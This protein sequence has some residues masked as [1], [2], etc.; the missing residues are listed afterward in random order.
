M[1]R[2]GFVKEKRNGQLRVCFQR[3]EACEGCKGCAKG[4]LP[5][6]E[7]LT[8]FGQAEVGDVVDVQM[9]EARTLK[10]TLLAYALPLLL[11]LAGLGTASACGLSDGLTLLCA[12]IGLAL[13][14]LVARGIDL[15]LRADP[16][17][18]PTVVRV[19][20]DASTTERK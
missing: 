1:V 19:H 15:R 8:V 2:T 5:R 6:Q 3:P 4:L 11:L 17:W 12:L 13:G 9:P 16:K 7:L 14:V 20:A 18:R 10:A